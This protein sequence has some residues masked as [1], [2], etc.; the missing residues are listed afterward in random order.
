MKYIGIK[1]FVGTI[2]YETMINSK[3][4]ALDN[5]LP[6]FRK[7][8]GYIAFSKKLSHVLLRRSI[9]VS[10]IK[11]KKK[12]VYLQIFISKMRDRIVRKGLKKERDDQL[13]KI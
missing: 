1:E 12:H 6:N 7:I 9:R 11:L 13:K 8:K 5:F 4:L 2:S 3:I 10:K